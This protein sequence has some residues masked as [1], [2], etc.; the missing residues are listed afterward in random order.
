MFHMLARTSWRFGQVDLAVALTWPSR[1]VHT[2][3]SFCEAQRFRGVAVS[4]PLTAVLVRNSGLTV[5]YNMGGFDG[6]AFE[7]L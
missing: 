4:A 1:V 7:G 3:A 2:F 6:D 5:V